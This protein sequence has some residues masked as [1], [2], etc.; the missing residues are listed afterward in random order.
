MGRTQLTQMIIQ[1][2][3]QDAKNQ[4][5]VHESHSLVQKM[6]ADKRKRLETLSSK[7]LRKFYLNLNKHV[8]EKWLKSKQKMSLLQKAKTI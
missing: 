3:E 5:Y 7:E 1:L 6:E 4:H 2:F 8:D